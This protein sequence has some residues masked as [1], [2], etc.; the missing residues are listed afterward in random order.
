[1]KRSFFIPLYTVHLLSFAQYVYSGN[2]A[3]F[4]TSRDVVRKTFHTMRKS[5][6][7]ELLHYMIKCRSLTPDC[8]VSL[9]NSPDPLELNPDLDCILNGSVKGVA[10]CYKM[11]LRYGGYYES[12]INPAPDVVDLHKQMLGEDV[13][14]EA[15]KKE[16]QEKI[17][18][19]SMPFKKESIAVKAHPKKAGWVCRWT[20]GLFGCEE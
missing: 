10:A 15:I 3:D 17:A 6:Q 9:D 4:N 20:L 13:D 2:T 11:F 8:A 14:Y 1:M 7:K 18:T 12:Y 5:E 16:L 19:Q